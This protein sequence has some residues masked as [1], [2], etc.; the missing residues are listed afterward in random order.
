MNRGIGHAAEGEFEVALKDLDSALEVEPGMPAALYNRGN[1]NLDLSNNEAAIRDFSDVIQAEPRFALA[2]L[3]RGLAREQA[4]DLEGAQRDLEQA[5]V[6][7][8]SLQP[9]R[10]ALARIKKDR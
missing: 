6:L 1:V 8:K 4:G 9:A 2:W 5:L 7:D 3:N 10:R